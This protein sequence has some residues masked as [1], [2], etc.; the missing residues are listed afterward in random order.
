MPFPQPGRCRRG[1]TWGYGIA[2]LQTH[3]PP[4]KTWF[5]WQPF[6]H[7]LIR[8]VSLHFCSFMWRE[9]NTLS[10]NSGLGVHMPLSLLQSMQTFFCGLEPRLWNNSSWLCLFIAKLIIMRPGNDPWRRT[11]YEWQG[12]GRADLFHPHLTVAWRTTYRLMA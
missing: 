10:F 4:S 3:C 7:V 8:R 11:T 5:H 1:F 2:E 6:P 9:E 12:A